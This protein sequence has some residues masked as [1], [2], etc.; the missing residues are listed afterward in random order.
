MQQLGKWLYQWRV[1]W[2]FFTALSQ[3]DLSCVMVHSVKPAD[4]AFVHRTSLSSVQFYVSWTD[5]SQAQQ[6]TAWLQVCICNV[7][8]ILL[9]LL[10][11]FH[12]VPPFGSELYAL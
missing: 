7:L 11:R 4:T 5:A 3:H 1:Q 10:T 8:A 6:C 12:A 9:S 2:T